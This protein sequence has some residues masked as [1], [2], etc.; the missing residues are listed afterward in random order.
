MYLAGP[1]TTQLTFSGGKGVHVAAGQYLMLV[2]HLNNTSASTVT[3]STVIE[4]RVAAAKDVTTA[5][6]MFIAGTVTFQLPADQDSIPING[7]C[8]TVADSHLV[9]DVPLMR[10]LGTH[11]LVT[12][13][14]TGLDVKLF[15]ASFDPQHVVYSTLSSDFDVPAGSHINV[16]CT[17]DNTTGSVVGF[18][19]SSQDELCFAGIYR[20]PPKPP[21]N[22]APVDCAL[23]NDI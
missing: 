11:S 20:Y 16:T 7:G 9:A 1:G 21:T 10:A 13:T 5:I 23:G 19:Q 6:D 4:G 14:N 18:G 17:Y 3:A 12:I 2:T 15:D 22:M 8:G